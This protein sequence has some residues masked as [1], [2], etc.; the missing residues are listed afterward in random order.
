[1]HEVMGRVFNK[2]V[3]IKQKIELKLPEIKKL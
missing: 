2:Y 1:M 3:Q